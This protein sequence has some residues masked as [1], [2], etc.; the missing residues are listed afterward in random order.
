MIFEKNS[1]FNKAG[2]RGTGHYTSHRSL[3][4]SRKSKKQASKYKDKFEQKVINYCT[5]TTWLR[6][7]L[8]DLQGNERNYYFVSIN[9]RYSFF[10]FFGRQT[11][12]FMFSQNS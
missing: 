3:F 5:K 7:V 4:A 9:F 8:V 1:N 10:N 11:K 12:E 6:K 2:C